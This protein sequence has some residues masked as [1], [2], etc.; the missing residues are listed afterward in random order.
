MVLRLITLKVADEMLA[1]I[2]AQAKAAGLTRSALLLRPF[3]NDPPQGSHVVVVQ[4]K[5]T[6]LEVGV[7][8]SRFV[9]VDAATGEPLPARAP[10]QK[11]C[12]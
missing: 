6:R 1:R 4:P 10:Y 9:G 7:S 8:E 3:D 5:R 11:A 2:D 12:K